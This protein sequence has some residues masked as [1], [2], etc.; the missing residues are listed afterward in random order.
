MKEHFCNGRYQEFVNHLEQELEFTEGVNALSHPIK[1]IIVDSPVLTLAEKQ[2]KSLNP[3]I[4]RLLHM[5]NQDSVVAVAVR[6]EAE[7]S[8]SFFFSFFQTEV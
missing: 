5:C 1:L 2:E 8:F 3:P 6:Y 7:V 4:V